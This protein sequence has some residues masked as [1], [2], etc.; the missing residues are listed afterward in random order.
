MPSVEAS[1]GCYCPDQSWNCS[2]REKATSAKGKRQGNLHSDNFFYSL[3]C[4]FQTSSQP[5][6]VQQP[7]KLTDIS[8]ED[9]NTKVLKRVEFIR[10]T[11]KSLYRAQGKKPVSFYHFVLDPTSF[12]NSVEN[13]FYVSFLLK[14]G[15]AALT[16]GKRSPF[17]SCNPSSWNSGGNV[18][19]L[20][21]I[22]TLPRLPPHVVESESGLPELVIRN[23]SNDETQSQ[24]GVTKKQLILGFDFNM[25][26]VNVPIFVLPWQL[27]ITS[28]VNWIGNGA[29]PK[30]AESRHSSR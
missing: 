11:L 19:N 23:K 9:Q 25:W 10:A 2:Q 20:F 5:V 1:V 27:N 15:L 3:D 13:F 29:R 8:E 14:D 12:S 18:S 4:T 22:F 21:I 7:T 26:Q 24:G 16:E 28:N 6:A 17:Q 30:F